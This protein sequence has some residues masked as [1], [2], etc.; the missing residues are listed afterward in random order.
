MQGRCIFESQRLK[1]RRRGFARYQFLPDIH[2]RN[3]VGAFACARLRR[4]KHRGKFFAYRVAGLSD[5]GVKIRPCAVAEPGRH[6]FSIERFVRQIVRLFVTQH[7]H[8]I[9]DAS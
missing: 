9:F 3:R 6:A 7:L 8:A 2:C 5:V 4:R 1:I